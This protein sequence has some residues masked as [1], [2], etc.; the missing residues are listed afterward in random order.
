LEK[1]GFRIQDID[2]GGRGYIS[3]EDLVCYINVNAD[4]FFRS[5][6]A[7]P[8]F[9]RLTKVPLGQKFENRLSY[10]LFLGFLV[11]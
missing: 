3:T 1:E 9:R 2:L 10:E 4:T 8:I 5:R 11:K 7:C 6:D